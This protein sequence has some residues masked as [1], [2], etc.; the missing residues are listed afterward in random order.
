[1]LDVTRVGVGNFIRG[2]IAGVCHDWKV[3]QKLVICF[4][5]SKRDLEYWGTYLS[6]VRILMKFPTLMGSDTCPMGFC[7]GC[8]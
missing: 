6:Y 4:K 3:F 1:M 7:A 8:Y 2:R 5:T